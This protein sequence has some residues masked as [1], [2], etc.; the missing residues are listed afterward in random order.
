MREYFFKF[1]SASCLSTI[2]CFLALFYSCT[3]LLVGLYPHLWRV[4]YIWPLGVFAIF[5]HCKQTCRKYPSPV[6]CHRMGALREEFLEV[7]LWR[8]K[9]LCSGD[10]DGYSPGPTSPLHGNYTCIAPWQNTGTCLCVHL[11]QCS[12][13]MSGNWVSTAVETGVEWVFETELDGVGVGGNAGELLACPPVAVPLRCV[14]CPLCLSTE[15]A[16][17]VLQP[18]AVLQKEG[19]PAGTQRWAGRLPSAP[20]L[21]PDCRCEEGSPWGDRRRPLPHAPYR[22]AAS[23]LRQWG[24]GC[25]WHIVG[26]EYVWDENTEHLWYCL[27]E[28]SK[29]L[30]LGTSLVVQRLGIRASTA[31]G[32]GSIPGQ[33]TKSPHATQ[34]SQKKKKKRVWF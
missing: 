9:D 11:Q 5:C 10:V 18:A 29:R 19:R 23:P 22:L 25:V 8:S 7:Q 15:Q 28:V 3:E 21:V 31:E 32:T 20:A 12:W 16:G 4:S 13:V 34:Y 26:L 14:L 24:F 17:E 27:N 33:E 6:I 2:A 1:I 30:F